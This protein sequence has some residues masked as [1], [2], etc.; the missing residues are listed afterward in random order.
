MGL[1]EGQQH[2]G[3]TDD[4]ICLATVRNQPPE[5]PLLGCAI[6]AIHPAQREGWMW[7]GAHQVAAVLLLLRTDV[8]E[9][10]V[11]HSWRPN[12]V[13]PLRDLRNANLFDA[14]FS[15]VVCK[16]QKTIRPSHGTRT[17]A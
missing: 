1:V 15:Y 12:M 11:L 5:Y 3:A 10:F 4:A 9:R 14:N 7:Q 6:L 17:T 2:M 16:R 8:P 13:F